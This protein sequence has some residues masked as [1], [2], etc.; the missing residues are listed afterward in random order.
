MRLHSRLLQVSTHLRHRDASHD[1][2]FDHLVPKS[3]LAAPYVVYR[4]T[5]AISCS[6]SF[7]SVTITWLRR[8]LKLRKVVI[9]VFKWL[10]QRLNLRQ[11]VALAY[12][13]KTLP[14]WKMPKLLAVGKW[15]DI[16][17]IVCTI[18]FAFLWLTS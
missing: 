12:D 8:L 16:G 18:L 17:V 6:S 5:P 15:F 11:A 2:A 14:R 1:L 13:P 7:S 10:W 4:T 3:C 9:V